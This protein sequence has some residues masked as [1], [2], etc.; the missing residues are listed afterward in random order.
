MSS[1]PKFALAKV[2]A[3]TNLK[4]IDSPRSPTSYSNRHFESKQHESPRKFGGLKQKSEYSDEKIQEMLENYKEIPRTEWMSL[5]IGNHIR[6]IGK[7][8]KFRPGGFIRMKNSKNDHYYFLLENDKFGS[9]A[10]NPEYASWTMSF[11]NVTKIFLKNVDNLAMEQ[12]N[13]VEKSQIQNQIPSISQNFNPGV[14]V[15]VGFLQKQIDDLEKKYAIMDTNYKALQDKIADLQMF[16]AKVTKYLKL[17]DNTR[18][19]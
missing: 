10:R 4:K 19:L 2:I 6:Y 11:A 9:K 16:S 7:D 14:T 8:G 13:N 3:G 17:N 1:S 5:S 12:I 18:Y 15:E